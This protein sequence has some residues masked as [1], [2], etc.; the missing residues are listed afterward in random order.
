MSW[1]K[2]D[3]LPFERSMAFIALNDKSKIDIEN[4]LYGEAEKEFDS[5]FDDINYDED[6]ASVSSKFITKLEKDNRMMGYA[7]YLGS[8]ISKL[9]SLE[10]N[11]E[12]RNNTGSAE[13]YRNEID[14]LVS[15]KE[16]IEEKI[17]TFSLDAENKA[18]VKNAIYNLT[19]QAKKSEIRGI[20]KNG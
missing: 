7:G 9:I 2:I 10:K 1:G 19:E 4:K 11:A 15:K 5:F 3:L 14:K 12:R 8:K 20:I 6:L 16:A 17:T 13:Y 18:N